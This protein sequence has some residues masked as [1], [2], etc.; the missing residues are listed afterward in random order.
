M[1]VGLARLVV[2]FLLA[3]S[4]GFAITNTLMLLGWI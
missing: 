2:S 3:L 4:F 1:S